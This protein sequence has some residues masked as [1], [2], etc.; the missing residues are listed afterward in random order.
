MNRKTV[1]GSIRHRMF[2]LIMLLMAVLAIFVTLVVYLYAHNTT[3]STAEDENMNSAVQM[4]RTNDVIFRQSVITNI[5]AYLASPAQI[6]MDKGNQNNLVNELHDQLTDLCSQYG[7][8]QRYIYEMGF[9]S[10]NADSLF[11]VRR[12]QSTEYNSPAA[13]ADSSVC[14][15]ISNLSPY[16]SGCYFHLY[17][18]K[19]PYVL[20]FIKMN[21]EG[22]GATFLTFDMLEMRNFVPKEQF[23]KF[24]IISSDGQIM[25]SNDK[26]ELGSHVS[27]IPL[28][29]AWTSSKKEIR[30]IYEGN[31]QFIANVASEYFDWYYVAVRDTTDIHIPLSRMRVV[32]VLALMC[33]FFGLVYSFYISK[34]TA[35]PL[36]EV[37]DMLNDK[38][39]LER[40]YSNKE[41]QMIARKL[42]AILASNRDM[43]TALEDTMQE[44]SSLQNI[45]L[46]YQINPHFLFNTLNLVSMVTANEF[47]PRHDVV[48]MISKLSRI[49]RYSL[50]IETNMVPLSAELGYAHLY[51]DILKRRHRGIFDVQYEIPDGL[52]NYQVLRLSLQPLIENA[53]YHGIQPKGGGIL[54]IGAETTDN[55][56]VIWVADDGVGM[57]EEKTAELNE[58]IHEKRM[59]SEHIGLAN[60]HR[61]LQI[62]FGDS[63]GVGVTSQ[64]GKSVKVTMT[65]PLKKMRV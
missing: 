2:T 4:Q 29:T 39:I 31:E 62:L 14:D 3:Y 8:I 65:L 12:S 32:W 43:Q 45:A 51:V 57:S 28:L 30:N 21:R 26:N 13:Y 52:L 44:F 18:N 33:L 22:T 34:K 23:T 47:G 25:F 60:I 27:D 63:Y 16:E 36:D 6:Y 11:I 37:L 49:L 40:Q 48:T 50:D 15:F 46:Q 53:I 24:Y 20:T 56:L 1:F 5:F 38:A 59:H 41:M 19:H 17:Q 55:T 7:Y 61:R 64:E 9:Y 42:A 10:M 35:Q 58:R 54:T